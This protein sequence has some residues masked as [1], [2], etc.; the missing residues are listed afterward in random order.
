MILRPLLLALR[1]RWYL[2]TGPLRQRAYS[3]HR[4]A[5]R[6]AY[7]AWEAQRILPGSPVTVLHT[8]ASPARIEDAAYLGDRIDG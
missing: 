6:R 7:Q 3:R 5:Q 4:K 8:D 1:R 2:A